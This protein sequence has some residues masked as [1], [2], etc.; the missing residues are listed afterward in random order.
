MPLTDV[1]TDIDNRTIVMTCDFPVS[2]E[3][4]W[5][6]WADPRQLEQW[7]GPES[8]PA[9]VTEHDL[10]PGGLVKYHM[11]GP[12]GQRFPGG[13]EVIA[14]EAPHRLE[15]RD[16]FADADGNPVESAPES[17]IVIEITATEDGS[18]M[19]NTSTWESV[20]AMQQVLD[21]GVI[22]GSSSAIG[23]LDALLAA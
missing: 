3:R 1:T 18:R 10:T 13:W 12:D 8:H 6:V 14:V 15:V 9:T 19:V 20:E 11:T 17:R 2:P 7:W 21:M 22:E 4:L 16:F 5:Q 23:Q